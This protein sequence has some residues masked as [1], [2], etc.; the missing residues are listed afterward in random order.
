MT[1]SLYEAAV[2]NKWRLSGDR[3]NVNVL[4]E[5]YFEIYFQRHRNKRHNNIEYIMQDLGKKANSYNL[6]SDARYRY[7][8]LLAELKRLPDD[9]SRQ[10]H[11]MY[12]NFMNFGSCSSVYRI[13]KKYGRKEPFGPGM[14][15]YDPENA[16]AVLTPVDSQIIYYSEF[17]HKIINDI[18]DY[19]KSCENN[20]YLK[21]LMQQ[22]KFEY[23]EPRSLQSSMTV[24]FSFSNEFMKIP[25]EIEIRRQSFCIRHQIRRFRSEE[26]IFYPDTYGEYSRQR[27]L[28]DIVE[29]FLAPLSE[30]FIQKENK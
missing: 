27:I 4:F 17:M 5:A 30:T 1:V 16:E 12:Q 10:R 7:H 20:N 11:H 22:W 21:S 14:W 19:L 26:Q 25:F 2:V 29:N 9:E 8:S 15:L 24:N 13:L 23:S 18:K 6:M 28:S 3:C